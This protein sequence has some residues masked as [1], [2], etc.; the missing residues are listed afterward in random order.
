MRKDQRMILNQNLHVK[1]SG[2]KAKVTLTQRDGVC[3]S[4]KKCASVT[5]LNASDDATFNWKNKNA[6]NELR[7]CQ[8]CAGIIFHN[9]D[10]A[11]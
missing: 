4:K 10:V 5:V 7:K 8:I 6:D 2:V 1:K 3:T 9:E 11:A